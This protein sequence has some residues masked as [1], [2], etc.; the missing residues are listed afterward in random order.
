MLDSLYKS[1]KIH[2]KV[3]TNIVLMISVSFLM[4]YIAVSVTSFLTSEVMDQLVF[5]PYFRITVI[6][7]MYYWPQNIFHSVWGASLPVLFLI[8]MVLVKQFL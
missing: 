8:V 4:I 2:G 5:R 7:D 6:S 3:L 1:Q